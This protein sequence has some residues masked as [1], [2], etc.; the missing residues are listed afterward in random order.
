M[1]HYSKGNWKLSHED[2][3]NFEKLEGKTSNYPNEKNFLEVYD[4]LEMMEDY[5]FELEIRNYSHN[6]IKTY[7]SIIR[8]FHNFLKD[9]KELKNEKQVLRGFKRF[10]RHLKREKKVSQNYIYLVTVVVKKF[11]EFGGVH[12]LEEV[13]TPKRTKSLPKS[14]NED[15]VKTLINALD[16]YHPMDSDS[17]SSES[18]KLRNKLILALLYS[19]GL[20]VS[21]LVTLELNHVDIDER[22][23]RIRGKG[24]KDRIVLFDDA[25][26]EILVEYI[27]KRSCDSEY[28]FVNRRGNHLTPRYVQMM[29]K[30]YARVAGIKKKVTPHIL[31]HSFATHLL[32]NGVDIRAIQQLLGHS[33]LS[34]T[35]IYTS[36][37][38]E[39]LKNVYD[40]AKLV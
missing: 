7:R 37:D 39:T 33:N 15:E 29:I 18:L 1:T 25:T 19:S 2:P 23:I 5:L 17:P 6:T 28:I 14:L 16:S 31:R 13:K 4:L 8:N 27:Q 30:D 35:Q 21:E 10:I 38:M 26:R 11:F 24:E 32:K 22:T 3:N 20:R 34:T 12:I 36:V 40:R 9:E